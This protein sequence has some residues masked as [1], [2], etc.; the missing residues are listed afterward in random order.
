MVFLIAAVLAQSAALVLG[1]AAGLGYSGIER[2]LSIEY[3]GSLAALMVQALVWQQALKRY[4]LS[5]AYPFM[6]AV[7][8]IIP[9]VS[10]FV[11]DE[12]ISIGQIVGAVLIAAGTVMLNR[13]VKTG[14]NVVVEEHS[15]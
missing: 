11:F 14:E 8:L 12:T 6:S 7:F 5:V 2:Y 4:P 15:T 9:A 3:I 13:T 1:K 10:Y